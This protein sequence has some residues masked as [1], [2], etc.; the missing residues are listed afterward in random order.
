MVDKQVGSNDGRQPY[1]NYRVIRSRSAHS[2]EERE[3]RVHECWY[4]RGQRPNELPDLWTEEPADVSGVD[5]DELRWSLERMVAAL[6][7]PIL[8][9]Q[10][11]QLRE[12]R[13]SVDNS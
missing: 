2:G 10:D 4:D 11:G 5:L 1:W 9:E 12:V 3:Y 6:K 7:W 8:F 13:A